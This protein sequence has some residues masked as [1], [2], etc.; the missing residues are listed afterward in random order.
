MGSNHLLL[1]TSSLVIAGFRVAEALLVHSDRKAEI[2]GK[3]S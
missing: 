2:R 1:I 3:L